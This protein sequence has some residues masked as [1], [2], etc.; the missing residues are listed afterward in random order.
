MYP[1]AQFG[2]WKTSG[3]ISSEERVLILT[4]SLP[5]PL[6]QGTYFYGTQQAFE[7]SDCHQNYNGIDDACPLNSPHISSDW[8]KWSNYMGP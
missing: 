8:T 3:H 4:D 7:K 6:P 1:V 2:F 5:V